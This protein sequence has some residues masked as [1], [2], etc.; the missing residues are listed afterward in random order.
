MERKNKNYRT[1]LFLAIFFCVSV[2]TISIA[3]AQVTEL[4]KEAKKAL[5]D[6]Q[7]QLDAINAKIKA[8][9]QIIKLK[10]SQGSTLADQIQ[11]LQAQADKLEFEIGLNK[12]K[13]N[14]LE[15]DITSLSSRI[16]EKE[17]LISRQ[18][19]MLSELMRVYYSDYS[20]G[21]A[22][23]IFSADETFSYLNQEGWTTE[24]NDK[25]SDL[26]DSVK[27][28]RESLTGERTTL[29]E[30]KKEAD[31]LHM[32]LS[33]RNEYLEVTRYNK[34][35]LLIKTQAE[36][37]KYDGLVDD[38]KAQQKALED[39]IN[40]IESGKVNQLSG[41][42]SGNGQLAYP[43]VK[44][45]DGFFKCTSNPN[46]KPCISQFYGK[47]TC[48]TCGYTFHNGIDF[49]APKNTTVMAAASGKVKDT[50]NMGTGAYGKWVTIEHD[51]GAK[52]L[53]T[54]YGHLNSISVSKGESVKQGDII[55][56]VGTTGNSTGY[57]LH[58]TVYGTSTYEVTTFKSGKKGPTGGH[59]NPSKYLK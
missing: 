49:A 11:S 18:K 19:Q 44:K 55:G 50:G 22:T 14:D 36:V 3:D 25:I 5:D 28:L 56:K 57:H 35:N 1:S 16:T 12:K 39:E 21:A 27:T 34:A 47:P 7:D 8:Y 31:A 33:T 53:T 37:N 41:L 4:S 17:S 52:G 24:V 40:D 58:F 30:K 13:V 51:G 20:G 29:E 59:I 9:N 15:G 46:N 23:L 54:L 6:R 45:A 10:Q 26:L 32:Q 43:F 48:K 42:P 2:F 38:L